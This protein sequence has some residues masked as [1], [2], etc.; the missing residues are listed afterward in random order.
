MMCAILRIEY[1]FNLYSFIISIAVLTKSKDIYSIL[2][3][4]KTVF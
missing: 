2:Q 3:E 4:T 1:I